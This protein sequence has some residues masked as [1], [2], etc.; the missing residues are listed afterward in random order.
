MHPRSARRLL[1]APGGVRSLTALQAAVEAGAV[2]GSVWETS[3]TGGHRF[4]ANVVHLPSGTTYARVDPARV[5][6]L[7]A[8]LQRG[9]LQLDAWRGNARH[10]R[11]VQAAEAFLRR[12]LDV[13]GLDEVAYRGAAETWEGHRHVF[14]VTTAASR[15]AVPSRAGGQATTSRSSSARPGHHDRCRTATTS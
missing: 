1:R 9:R 5:G 7:A 11:P 2:T 13:V 12:A 10:P 8:D 4:A 3:H 6:A 14:T 15:L